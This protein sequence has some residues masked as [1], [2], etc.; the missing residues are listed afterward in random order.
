MVAV[1]PA[2]VAADP[3]GVPWD[4][5]EAGD[6]GEAS[7]GAEGVHIPAGAGDELRPQLRAHAG[8]AENHFRVAVLSE[9]GR[10]PC[11]DVSDLFVQ[12]QDRPGQGVH[13]GGRCALPG[14][15]GVLGP[16]RGDGHIGHRLGAMDFAVLQPGREPGRSGAG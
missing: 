7:R 4:R 6:A 8:H 15:G 11:V 1:W 14:H 16:S 13:H 3:T 2:H 12:S 10:D 5:Y 9:S